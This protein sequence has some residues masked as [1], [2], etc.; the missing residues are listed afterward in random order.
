MV[1][2]E[3]QRDTLQPQRPNARGLEHLERRPQL[4]DEELVARPNA[5]HDRLEISDLRVL[6]TRV[7]KCTPDERHQLDCP[8]VGERR[9]V[10]P[11]AKPLPLLNS[12]VL[13]HQSDKQQ[14]LVKRRELDS[15][16]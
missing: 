10:D 6:D 1:V 14:L 4:L 9:D 12:A 3:D 8:A 13:R 5:V 15:Q 2:R 7:N 11:R 16:R